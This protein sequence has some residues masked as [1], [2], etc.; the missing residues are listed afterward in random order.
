MNFGLLFD[1]KKILRIIHKS[2]IYTHN[3]VEDYLYKKV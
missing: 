1:N 2:C 3:K